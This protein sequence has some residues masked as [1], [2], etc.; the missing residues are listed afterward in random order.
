MK[1]ASA[2]ERKKVAINSVAVQPG[3]PLTAPVVHV[4]GVSTAV[5]SP[6]TVQPS[7][8]DPSG[9]TRGAAAITTGTDPGVGR[10][11]TVDTEAGL[12]RAASAANPALQ[13]YGQ[14][15][16]S[17]KNTNH[18]HVTVSFKEPFSNTDYS[19]VASVNLPFCFTVLQTKTAEA[20]TL[21]IIRTQPSAGS[22]GCL[23]WIAFG[24]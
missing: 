19:F 20:A 17:F 24:S 4:S 15:L 3:V 6:H 12:S 22:A 8:V 10:E 7:T 14:Q 1:I 13:Q 21:S 5:S 23:N 18:I 11:A 16:F 2:E 9:Y